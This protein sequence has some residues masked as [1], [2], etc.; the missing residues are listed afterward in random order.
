MIDGIRVQRRLWC[1]IIVILNLGLH[2]I[3]AFYD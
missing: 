2:G 3:Y 1:R